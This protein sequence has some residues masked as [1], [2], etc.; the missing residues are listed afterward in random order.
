MYSQPKLH[1]VHCGVDCTL[2]MV[3]TS[4]TLH[5]QIKVILSSLDHSTTMALCNGTFKTVSWEGLDK[6]VKIAGQIDSFKV[7]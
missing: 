5:L 7:P 2:Y 6:F 3:Y 1:G 4:L